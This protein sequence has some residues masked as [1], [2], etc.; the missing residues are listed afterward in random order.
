MSLNKQ[1]MK[2]KWPSMHNK[3]TANIINSNIIQYKII[4]CNKIKKNF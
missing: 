4:N 1:T 2:I 3:L